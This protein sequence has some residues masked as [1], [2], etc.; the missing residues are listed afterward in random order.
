MKKLALRHAAENSHVKPDEL[1][2]RNA[3]A[4]S[5]SWSAARSLWTWKFKLTCKHLK[6]WCESAEIVAEMSVDASCAVDFSIDVWVVKLVE[7]SAE[8]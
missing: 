2:I 5:F 8:V 3:N 6:K 4:E 1:A 7:T